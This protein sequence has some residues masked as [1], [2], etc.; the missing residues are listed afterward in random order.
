MTRR[1]TRLIA[2]AAVLSCVATISALSLVGVI[3]EAQE[4]ASTPRPPTCMSDEVRER[5]RGIMIDAIDDALHDHIKTLFGVWMKDERGQPAR[6]EIGA[7]QAIRAHQLS[8][9][10]AVDWNPP[11]C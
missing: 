5:V 6:A 7:R 9:K 8:R 11:E 4:T 3:A 10:S 1:E 2:W